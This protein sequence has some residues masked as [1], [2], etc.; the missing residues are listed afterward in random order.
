MSQ[1]FTVKRPGQ[2]RRGLG[3][4]HPTNE[5]SKSQSSRGLESWDT[6]GTLDKSLK[7]IMISVGERSKDSYFQDIFFSF[8]MTCVLGLEEQSL[9]YFRELLFTP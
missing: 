3:I 7:D 8:K 5:R 4:L 6:R 2:Y 9:N 1:S